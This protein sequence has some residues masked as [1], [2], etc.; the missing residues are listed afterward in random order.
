MGELE[1]IRRWHESGDQKRAFFD[2]RIWAMYRPVLRRVFKNKC[3]YCE[4]PIA[5]VSGSG[6]VDQFRPKSLYWWLAYEL[7]NL[8]LA[9]Q[10]CNRRY[11]RDRFPLEDEEARA[12]G[13][14]GDLS[15]ESPLLIDPCGEEEPNDHL[16]FKGDGTVAAFTTKGAATIH[17][18]G[19]DRELLNDARKQA[20]EEATL[21]FESLEEWSTDFEDLCAPDVPYAAAV[22]HQL[23]RLRKEQWGEQ[24]EESAPAPPPTRKKAAKKK[25]APKKK[26]PKKKGREIERKGVAFTPSAEFES[27]E[28]LGLDPAWIYEVHVKD[29]KSLVDERIDLRE[30]APFTDLGPE[31]NDDG[32]DVTPKPRFPWLLLLGENAAGKSTLLEAITIA[33]ASEEVLDTLDPAD[34]IRIV[35]PGE[36][37]VKEASVALLL[38]HPGCPSI[39]VRITR[40]DGFHRET[41]P[42]PRLLVRAY[43]AMRLLPDGEGTGDDQVGKVNSVA[44]L[45]DARAE[46]CDIE[47]WLKALWN[48]DKEKYR[49]AAT[50][51]ISL[52]P[53]DAVQEIKTV[54]VDGN[55]EEKVFAVS[56]GRLQ[57]LK[58]LS[59]G[60]RTAIAVAGDLMSAVPPAQL[61]DLDQVTGI[62]I[63]D[64]IGTQLHP[65]WRMRIVGDFRRAFPGV[66]FIVSTH[67]PLCLRGAVKTEIVRVN[68]HSPRF[69]ALDEDSPDPQFMR[70]DQ[71]L[72]SR[73]FGLDSTIDPAVDK[74][75]RKYYALLALPGRD[76]DQERECKELAA[77]LSRHN[78]LGYTRRD[79]LIYEIIDK[80]LAESDFKGDEQ[81]E[82]RISEIP[83]EIRQRVI[84][85]WS[86]AHLRVN[87]SK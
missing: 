76:D 82:R 47:T 38:D 25:K 40:E 67:E 86:Y 7:D 66:Q 34:F 65:R 43:G 20:I 13:E 64:E 24:L 18:L 3:A 50:K 69:Q 58:S 54:D 35:G 32:G 79:Q 68:V 46:M 63:I 87:K 21:K 45:F 22:I 33:L 28:R 12:R 31:V 80:F 37:E 81:Q 84:D 9:C 41:E 29:F 42:P 23:H 59:G 14:G 15:L 39:T 8:Y 75:F 2:T 30:P 62:V 4:T 48:L 11:K 5:A 57:P 73:L 72:T 26:A 61:N 27:A 17:I 51:L 10:D 77:R 1:K 70:V 83:P 52:L 60:Y 44:N 55:G 16:D 53:G 6:D 85:L 19:L 71:L 49:E 36:E 56:H 74:E 78:T